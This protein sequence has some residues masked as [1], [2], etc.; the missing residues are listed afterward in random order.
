M[1][2]YIKALIEKTEKKIEGSWFFV[3]ARTE[4]TMVLILPEEG[5]AD[6]TTG[7]AP[8]FAADSDMD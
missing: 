3:I 1:D 6:G 5:S 4:E 7:N 8:G 2:D